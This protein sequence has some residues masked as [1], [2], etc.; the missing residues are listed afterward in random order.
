M[1]RLAPRPPRRWSVIIM[2]RAVTLTRQGL[3]FGEDKCKKHVIGVLKKPVIY[4]Q[5]W[6]ETQPTQ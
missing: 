5:D 3:Q 4:A 1:Q 2:A 6:G